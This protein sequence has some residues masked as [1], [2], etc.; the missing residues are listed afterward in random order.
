MRLTKRVQDIAVSAALQTALLFSMPA[1]AGVSV[2]DDS[3]Q[4]I[5]LQ[6]PAQRIVSLAPHTTELLFAAG[7][8]KKVVGV[9]ASSDYPKEVSRLPLTGDSTRL[10]L[11]RITRLKPDLILAWRSGNNP[12]QLAQLR[13]LGFIIFESEPRNFDDIASTLDK[14]ATLTDSAQGHDAAT[15]FTQAMNRLQMR[16]QSREQVSVFY[17]IWRSPLMTLNSQ[18]LVSQALRLCG[19]RNIFAGLSQLAPTVSHEAVV[20][21]NP[22]AILLSDESS[23]GI[24]DWTTMRQ[25]KAVRH[26]QV[27]RVNGRLLNRSG[28]RM[29]EAVATLC[30]QIDSV[31]HHTQR[32]LP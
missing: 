27:I 8:G 20:S 7:A 1:W 11:E 29:P 26:Q 24:D 30:E 9:S 4:T 21:A 12:R 28:P 6:R 13:S 16:Y 31:R 18:H 3:G 17:Q 15:Q 14:L 5:S 19:A 23:A 32:P 22:D 2:I 25:L 10:D